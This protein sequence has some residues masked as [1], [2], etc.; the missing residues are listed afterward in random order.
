MRINQFVARSAN[1]S[2]RQADNLIIS[3]N[4]SVNGQPAKIG[5]S[6]NSTDQV[7]LDGVNL[8]LSRSEIILLNKP[9]GYVCSRNSQG[10]KT[11]YQLLPKELRH[12]NSVGRLD[13]NSS[14]LLLFTNN[15]ELANRL[16]HPKF[17]KIKTYRVKLHRQLT[18]PDFDHLKKGV[19]LS[20]GVSQ[21]FDVKLRSRDS[22][23]VSLTEGKNRQI[24]RTFKALGY[25]VI[26]LH[27][28]SFGPYQ[29]E[30]L[31]IGKYKEVNNLLE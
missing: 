27:R 7:T 3:G 6:I 30:Q 10:S 26:E 31:A 12:L 8:S 28:T 2:R 21:F 14:G 19:I 24:R 15:G 13:K 5:Q 22:L 1:V 9:V 20:D 11:V 23:I 17:Q 18:E 29:L 25:S 4:V 16:M